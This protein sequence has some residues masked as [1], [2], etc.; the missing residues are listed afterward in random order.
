LEQL[1]KT[2]QEIEQEV[3]E[4]LTWQHIQKNCRIALY[5][6]ASFGDPKQRESVKEWL[7]AKAETL[8]RA[9]AQR[10]RD[11]DL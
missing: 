1:Q 10:I 11:L 5:N 7:R 4:P 6:E 8:H 3:G 2:K 9:F